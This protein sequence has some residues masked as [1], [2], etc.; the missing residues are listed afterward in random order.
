MNRWPAIASSTILHLLCLLCLLAVPAAR[1]QQGAAAPS[2]S[3]LTV[4]GPIGPAYADYIER[5]IA[6]A[7]ARGQRL[8]VLQLDTPGGLDTAMRVIV[9]AILASPLPVACIVAPSGA[10]AA[11]AGTYILYACHV[12]STSTNRWCGPS[13]ARPK[14]NAS[15]APR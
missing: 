7:A 10:R 9:R 5:G 15:G 4:D 13:P 12:A 6:Q 8:V 3:L 11:S 1:A 14:P 2:A